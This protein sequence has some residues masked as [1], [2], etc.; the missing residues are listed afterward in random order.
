MSS[1][2]VHHDGQPGRKREQLGLAKYGAGGE[3]QIVR[4]RFDERLKE[5]ERGKRGRTTEDNPS[6]V[7]G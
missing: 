7:L 6:K 5:A 2:Q 4:E 3:T 1:T